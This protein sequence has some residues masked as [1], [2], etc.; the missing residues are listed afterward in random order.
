MSQQRSERLTSTTTYRYR[1]EAA[2]VESFR[3]PSQVPD[4]DDTGKL[5]T[6]KL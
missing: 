5:F 3:P 1:S 4:T 2:W 6:T